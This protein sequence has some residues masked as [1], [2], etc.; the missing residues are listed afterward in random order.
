M[1]EDFMAARY[2][3][4]FLIILA[5]VL[6]GNFIITKLRRKKHGS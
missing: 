3:A 5:V 6:G 1:P 4:I 2:L